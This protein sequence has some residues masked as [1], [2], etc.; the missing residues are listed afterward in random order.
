[1]CCHRDVHDL[2]L[3]LE[4]SV[5]DADGHDEGGSE[6]ECL[7][8]SERGRDNEAAPFFVAEERVGVGQEMRISQ[9]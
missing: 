5:T 8:P 1:M 3:M 2:N 9:R 4:R 7:V 6:M